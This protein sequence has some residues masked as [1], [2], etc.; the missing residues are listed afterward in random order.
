MKLADYL[1][2]ARITPA[3]LR[4]D[5]GIRGRSTVTRWL[6]GERIPSHQM[7]HRLTLYT[8]GAVQLV[9]YLDR[10]TLPRCATVVTLPEGRRKIVLPWSN[11]DAELDAC[12]AALEDEE[13]EADAHS[14][15]I[16]RALATLGPRAK[17]DREGLFIVDGRPIDARGLI[18]AAN[19]QLAAWGQE[20]IQYP[21]LPAVQGTA[22]SRR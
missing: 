15:P 19:K 13:R 14:P 8:K 6:T 10:R 22:G 7:I 3:K 21:G 9:D 16:Q 11:R 1:H 2:T 18:V 4:R 12:L 17:P 20:L 5:L